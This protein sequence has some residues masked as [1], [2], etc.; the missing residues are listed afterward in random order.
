MSRSRKQSFA[1]SA[2]F[3][4]WMLAAGVLLIGFMLLL[5]ALSD[6]SGRLRAPGLGSVLYMAAV[7]GVAAF[8]IY[9]GRRGSVTRN[10]GRSVSRGSRSMEPSQT[11]WHRWW[12]PNNEL[13]VERKRLN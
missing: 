12:K 2:V 1:N 3:P 5:G 10:H 13:L 7:S 4:R 9:S 11:A 6:A 8:L